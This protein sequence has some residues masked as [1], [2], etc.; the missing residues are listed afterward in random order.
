MRR[1]RRPWL[2]LQHI[3]T[4]TG[5]DSW[6]AEWRSVKSALK[7]FVEGQAF[8]PH[9]KVFVCDFNGSALTWQHEVLYSDGDMDH[10]LL[11]SSKWPWPND[12]RQLGA[13][14]RLSVVRVESFDP[15]LLRSPLNTFSVFHSILP[16]DTKT[17]GPDPYL[18]TAAKTKICLTLQILAC[19]SRYRVHP[20]VFSGG[21]EMAIHL[22]MSWKLHRH[23]RWKRFCEPADLITVICHNATTDIY[24]SVRDHENA[25]EAAVCNFIKD[26]KYQTLLLDKRTQYRHQ[27]RV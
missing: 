18:Q 24:P 6:T 21:P 4:H 14:I 3:F 17:W 2:H 15:R 13:W 16:V 8:S 19:L 10:F 12:E 11:R 27:Q 5:A 25:G 20:A 1:R 7:G 22:K 9:S 23:R 26:N